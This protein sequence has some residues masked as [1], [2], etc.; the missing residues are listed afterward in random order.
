MTPQTDSGEKRAANAATSKYLT[1]VLG[2][3]CYGFEI[4][5]VTEIIGI[6]PTTHIPETPHYIN[7]VINLRGKVI[8]VMDMRAR[9]GLERREYDN[10]TCTVVINVRDHEVGLVVD[11]VQEVIDISKDQIE[12]PPRSSGGMS[13]IKGLGKFGDQVKILL[14]SERVLFSDSAMAGMLGDD[15]DG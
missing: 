2:D 4:E 5:H 7:G 1:F 12:P 11:T 15:D 6:Q 14:N 10:R 13:Y 3:E 9:F 8:P